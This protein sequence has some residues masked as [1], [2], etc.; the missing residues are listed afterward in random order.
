MRQFLEPL[1]IRPEKNIGMPLNSGN[2]RRWKRELD[3]R[4]AQGTNIV[5]EKTAIITGSCVWD[6]LE[7]QNA[8]TST[9]DGSAE[10]PGHRSALREFLRHVHLQYPNATLFWK[11]CTTTLVHIPIL[12]KRLKKRKRSRALQRIKYMSTS[13]AW[14]L[15][16]VQ[17]DILDMEVLHHKQ[18]SP[19]QQFFFLDVYAAFY[20]SP[21]H[22]V[23]GDGRHYDVKMNENAVP[24]FANRSHFVK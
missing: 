24:W 22:F 19:T 21:H 8:T 17:K 2:V 12:S 7:P 18:T 13:R 5:Q 3:R 15:Y 16:S 1:G 10:W 6:I 4:A 11:S 9:T 14:G 23:K 20:L